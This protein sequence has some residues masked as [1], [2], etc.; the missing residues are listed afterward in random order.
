M[1]THVNM[2]EQPMRDLSP[3]S[4]VDRASFTIDEFCRAHRIGRTTLHYLWVQGK[5]PRI[6][7]IGTRVLIS[8]EAAAAWRAERETESTQAA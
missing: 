8:I 6:Y 4:D 1:E 2:T 3:L 7:R 5:G